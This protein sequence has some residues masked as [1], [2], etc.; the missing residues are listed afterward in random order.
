MALVI[1]E[2]IPSQ[3]IGMA[4]FGIV[5]IA[6]IFFLTGAPIGKGRVRF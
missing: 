1:G 4:F 6:F 3:I 2:R 5:L